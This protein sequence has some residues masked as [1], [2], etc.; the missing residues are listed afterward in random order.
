MLCT[1]FPQ[2]SKKY[3]L[4]LSLLLSPRCYT[5][6]LLQRYRQALDKAVEISCTYNIPPLSGHTLV[7][8]GRW[9]TFHGKKGTEFCIPSES[10]DGSTEDTNLSA[11]VRKIRRTRL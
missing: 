6:E 9:L 1:V 11:S 10:S 5:P 7:L 8:F 2:L 4:S 3:L